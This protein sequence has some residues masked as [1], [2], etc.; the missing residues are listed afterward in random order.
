MPSL[1]RLVRTYDHFE[2]GV[3]LTAESYLFDEALVLSVHI[4]NEGDT[5][6]IDL[7]RLLQ[8]DE[9]IERI[10]GIGPHKIR[11]KFVASA[12]SARDCRGQ[13]R[14]FLVI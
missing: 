13:N 3:T 11:F 7:V 5:S 1:P 8:I 6:G 12:G 2:A 14:C 9:R 4:I 10:R